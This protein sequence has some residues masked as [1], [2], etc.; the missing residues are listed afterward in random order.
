MPHM[1]Q[2]VLDAFCAA[3]V[4]A[5]TVAGDNVDADGVDPKTG[6]QLPRV[7]VVE[8]DAG[9]ESE[10]DQT[11]TV[12]LDRRTLNLEV[13]CVLKKTTA[14]V[15]EAREFGLEVEKAIKGTSSQAQ[16]L[17]ALCKG[18][19]RMVASRIRISA[20]SAD[21]FAARVLSWRLVYFVKPAAPDVPA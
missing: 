11:I 18:G 20:D 10:P 3:I 14:A 8:G 4:A 5:G 13:H 9:E 1:Q 15:A 16:A 2:Q 7:V 17:R 12:R 19:V 6:A 21:T